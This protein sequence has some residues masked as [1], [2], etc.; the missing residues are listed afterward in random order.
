MRKY[1]GV[2]AALI[3]AGPVQGQTCYEGALGFPGF[4]GRTDLRLTGSATLDGSSLVLTP[5]LPGQI[6]AA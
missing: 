1:L 4:E 3:A 2:V 6:G 5:A